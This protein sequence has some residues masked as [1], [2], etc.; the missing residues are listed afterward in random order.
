E[1]MPDGGRLVIGTKSIT[2]SGETGDPGLALAPGRYAVLSVADTGHGMTAETASHVFEPFFTTKP[3]GKGTGLGLSTAYGI[4][5]QSGGEITIRSRIGEGSTF[6]VYLPIVDEA[7]TS[8]ASNLIAAAP[9]RGTETILLAEDEDT[10]RELIQ[11]VLQ[12]QGYAVLAASHGAEALGL[13]LNR[14]ERIDLL[15]TDL[16]M[17][18]MNGRDLAERST[19]AHPE[20]KVLYMSGYTDNTLVPGGM[21][22]TGM[23]FIQKPFSPDDLAR[24]IRQVL[25]SRKNC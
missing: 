15:V 3:K 9:A 14:G 4:V 11:E 19:A 13:A 23:E 22:T 12:N 20:M 1:V 10:V 24:R 2:I 16:V 6:D 25:D 17:P 5:R 7:A 21:L 8:P 18:H